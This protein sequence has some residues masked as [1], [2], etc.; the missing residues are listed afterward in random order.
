MDIMTPYGSLTKILIVL[1]FVSF[2][3]VCRSVSDEIP[4][5]FLV[6]SSFKRN[7]VT[8]PSNTTLVQHV[9]HYE[10]WSTTTANEGSY[11]KESC[12]QAIVQTT[13]P[14]NQETTACPLALIQIPIPSNGHSLGRIP[15]YAWTNVTNIEDMT[16]LEHSIFQDKTVGQWNHVV[17]SKEQDGWRRLDARVFLQDISSDHESC[18]TL[19]AVALQ[20]TLSNDGGMHRRL[21]HEVGVE[22]HP[23]ATQDEV[24]NYRLEFL[25]KV[26]LPQGL[27]VNI[28]DALE[29]V[30]VT[31][32]DEG[33]ADSVT[34]TMEASLVLVSNDT[35]IDEEQPSFASSSHAVYIALEGDVQ[36]TGARSVSETPRPVDVFFEFATKVH[37]RYPQPTG[38]WVPIT[39]LAP[40]LVGTRI[41]LLEKRE[42]ECGWTSLGLDHYSQ[43]PLTTFTAAGSLDDLVPVTSVT[44]LVALVGTVIMFRDIAKATARMES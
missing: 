25:I 5:I 6:H 37:V 38:G 21:Q 7:I 2:P 44:L 22:F 13:Q 20:S 14:G 42:G 15:V 19:S 24:Q 34:A 41:F 9:D 17:W 43:P 8:T 3:H 35:V 32:E 36:V 40:T 26:F 11:L 27:F 29:R 23:D 31:V 39:L 18:P 12:C 10:C 16:L 4:R 33:T 28:E 30:T 1:F